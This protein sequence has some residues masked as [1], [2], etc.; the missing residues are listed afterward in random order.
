M[1]SPRIVLEGRRADGKWEVYLEGE[2]TSP[3]GTCRTK[4][5]SYW[6]Y[7]HGKETGLGRKDLCNHA[8]NDA[9]RKKRAYE[10]F[11]PEKKAATKAAGAAKKAAKR[12]EQRAVRE[13]VPL[14]AA[15]GAT[16][17]PQE[18]I[19]AVL[20]ALFDASGD[21]S[22]AV[23]EL[24]KARWVNDAV[25]GAELLVRVG[26]LPGGSVVLAQLEAAKRRAAAAQPPPASNPQLAWAT[27]AR[28]RFM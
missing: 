18:H 6:Q 19:D 12:A 27:G 16:D 13:R 24:K 8:S 28:S 9:T 22:K 7:R 21:A 10:I 3:G 26:R 1:A 2:V 15:A 25:T 5:I 23:T 4:T 11:E 17:A 20:Q 14:D